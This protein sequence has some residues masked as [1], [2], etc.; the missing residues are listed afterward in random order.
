LICPAGLSLSTRMKN[1]SPK[2]LFFLSFFCLLI[3]PAIV[4]PEEN[5]FPFSDEEQAW[6]TSHP[7]LKVAN[8]LDWPPRNP[9]TEFRYFQQITENKS[10]R[11]LK[12]FASYE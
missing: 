9:K 7:G 11:A 8:E 4:F 5:K 3:P 1:I 12:P 6:L 2:F 10:L